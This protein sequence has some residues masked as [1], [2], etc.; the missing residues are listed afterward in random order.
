MN[1]LRHAVAPLARDGRF[2]GAVV[3]TGSHVGS[4]RALAE[5]AAD[6]AAIDCVTFAFAQDSPEVAGLPLHVLGNTV[7]TPGLPLIASSSLSPQHVELLR[8]ALQSALESN[9][10]RARALRLRDFAQTTREDYAALVDLENQAI[11]LGYPRLG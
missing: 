7:Q 1:V 9:P 3:Q 11:A 10:E 4:M 8:Y 6:V 2:F 5:G